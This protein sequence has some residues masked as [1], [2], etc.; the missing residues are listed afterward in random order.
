MHSRML[1]A[2]NAGGPHVVAAAEARA[3]SRSA[4]TSAAAQRLT[5]GAC[6][7]PAT[8]SRSGRHQVRRQRQRLHS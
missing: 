8:C 3:Q 2:V 1:Y 7:S 4:S 5:A 6:S